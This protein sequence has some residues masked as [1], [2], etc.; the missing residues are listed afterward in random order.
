M[1]PKKSKQTTPFS[2]YRELSWDDNK[3]SMFSKLATGSHI[4]LL[5]FSVH[6]PPNTIKDMMVTY[7]LKQKPNKNNSNDL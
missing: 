1:T 4:V 5:Q 7:L 2:K 3:I 6:F